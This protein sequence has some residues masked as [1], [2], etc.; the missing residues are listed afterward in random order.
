MTCVLI[1]RKKLDIHTQGE[2]HV[3]MK[4]EIRKMHLQTREHQRLAASQQKLGEACSRLS[5]TVLRRNQP[6]PHPAL[7]LLASRTVRESISVV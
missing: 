7:G 4:A 5:L 6:C 2:H 1:K 3:K